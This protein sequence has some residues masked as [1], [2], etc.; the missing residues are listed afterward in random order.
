MGG[1]TQQPKEVHVSKQRLA[2]FL[3]VVALLSL[4][5]GAAAAADH[6]RVPIEWHP[7]SGQAG[8][9][10]DGAMASLVRRDGGVT[11]RFQTNGLIP[12]HAYTIWFVVINNPAACAASP[13]SAPDAILN[14]ATESQVTYG[15]G[16]IAGASGRASFAGAFRTG[17]IEGWLP[18]RSLDDPRTAEIHLVLNDHGPALA[19]HL[20]SMIHSYRGGCSDASPFPAIFPPTALADG[21]VGPNTCLLFQSAV[22]TSP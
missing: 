9:V 7:Q 15:A 14:P 11:F 13:C 20:P 22:F 3:A 12:G 8:A 19:E 1:E 5:S 10:G 6:Q 4:A 2:T 18:D 17:P 21:E 16:N